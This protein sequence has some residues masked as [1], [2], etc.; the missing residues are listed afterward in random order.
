MSNPS[1]VMITLDDNGR[2]FNLRVAGIARRDGHLLVHRAKGDAFWT[3]PGGRVELGETCEA[4]LR[5][6]MIEELGLE[7]VVTR[8]VWSVENFFAL[9]GRNYHEIAFYYSMEVPTEFPF[10]RTEIVHRAQDSGAALEFRWIEVQ[11]EA[12]TALPLLPAFLPERLCDRSMPPG[13]LVWQG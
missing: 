7:V 13:H 10:S 3:L 4:A 2:R 1:R 8:M 11:H 9:S 5:R 6:E 12:M